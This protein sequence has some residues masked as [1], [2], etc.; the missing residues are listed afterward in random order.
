MFDY[1]ANQLMTFFLKI[2]EKRSWSL[3][4]ELDRKGFAEVWRRALEHSEQY[5]QQLVSKGLTMTPI[6]KT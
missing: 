5:H 4:L 3:P 1:V 6:E 2:S